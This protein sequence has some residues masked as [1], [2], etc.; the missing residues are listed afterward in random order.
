[1]YVVAKRFKAPHFGALFFPLRTCA[2]LE[3]ENAHEGK[4]VVGTN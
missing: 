3:E 2:R 1:M 4:V